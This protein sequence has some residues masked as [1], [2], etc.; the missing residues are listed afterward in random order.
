MRRR[1]GRALRDRHVERLLAAADEDERRLALRLAEGGADVG[2]RRHGRAVDFLEH[3]ADADA[4][5]RGRTRRIDVRD[6]EAGVT[7]GQGQAERAPAPRG[8][9]RDESSLAVRGISASLTLT[10]FSWPPRKSVSATV[11]PG[12]RRDTVVAERVAVARPPGRRS[13]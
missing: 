6:L 12:L 11:L 13:R 4:R 2:G 1:L 5:V 3:V 9:G 10:C 7:G 8:A